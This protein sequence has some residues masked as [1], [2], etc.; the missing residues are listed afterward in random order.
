MGVMGVLVIGMVIKTRNGNVGGSSVTVEV[1][2]GTMIGTVRR[3]WY[4]GDRD[5]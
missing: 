1:N 5:M 2:S 3:R 4:Q